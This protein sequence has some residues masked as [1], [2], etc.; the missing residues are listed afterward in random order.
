MGSNTTAIILV[1]VAVALVAVALWRG[2]V[3]ARYRK[4]DRPGLA[5]IRIAGDWL[6]TIRRRCRRSQCRPAALVRRGSR[7]APNS[8]RFQHPLEK[9]RQ[10]GVTSLLEHG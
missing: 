1:F 9:F 4:R 10:S 5:V 8:K 3:Q 6:T 2:V 7:R